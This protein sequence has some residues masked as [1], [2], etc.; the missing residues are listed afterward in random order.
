MEER[1]GASA[2]TAHNRIFTHKH[3]HPHLYI[4]MHMAITTGRYICY[5]GVKEREK[6]S[7]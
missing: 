2:S 1:K 5:L 7:E 4:R 6:E 3:G